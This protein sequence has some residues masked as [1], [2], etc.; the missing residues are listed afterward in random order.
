MI[1]KSNELAL[2]PN[3]HE[4]KQSISTL[5]GGERRWS[6]GEEC[7]LLEICRLPTA[8]T[9]WQAIERYHGSLV[10]GQRRFFPQS[11]YSL[12]SRWT[13]ILDRANMMP[14]EPAK[15]VVSPTQ[16]KKAILE[17]LANHPCNPESTA[18]DEDAAKETRQEYKLLKSKLK[19]INLEIAL[20]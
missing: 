11:K 1:T 17:L 7:M 18:Y 3:F 8:Q 4:L 20:K 5:Y 15:P 10:N 16:R 19:E 6:Y 2:P 9:E 13:E 12:L 14:T